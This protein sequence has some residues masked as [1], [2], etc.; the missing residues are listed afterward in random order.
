MADNTTE[1]AA[2][3][4]TVPAGVTYWYRLNTSG[5]ILDAQRS[6]GTEIPSN[7][8]EESDL[9]AWGAVRASLRH[10]HGGGPRWRWNGTRAME[11][12]D[13]RPTIQITAV[14]PDDVLGSL[15][16]Y[17]DRVLVRIEVRV[18]QSSPNELLALSGDLYLTMSVADGAVPVQLLA[19]DM[20]D[21]APVV[22]RL[23]GLPPGEVSVQPVA[24]GYKVEGDYRFLV[25]KRPPVTVVV[26]W[27][28]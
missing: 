14:A 24:G 8:V 22:V 12:A 23:S 17:V 20:S 27:E 9:A 15:P 25:A 26:G 28:A 3:A 7:G 1:G 11:M 16:V 4:L 10:T 2:R 21:G 13:R 6:R 19:V 18:Y 5:H